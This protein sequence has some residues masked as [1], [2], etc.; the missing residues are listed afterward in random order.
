MRLGLG[1]L[2]HTALD[3]AQDQRLGEDCGHPLQDKT[4]LAPTEVQFD[5]VLTD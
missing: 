1:S 2:L 5:Y 3:R 4:L